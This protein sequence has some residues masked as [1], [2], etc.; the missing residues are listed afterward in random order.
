MATAA[1]NRMVNTTVNQRREPALRDG[2]SSTLPR[3]QLLANA[4][5]AASRRLVAVCW[6]AILMIAKG[7]RP[8]PRHADWHSG[9]LHDPANDDAIAEHVE[10]V[11]IP[12]AG[13]ARSR[14][15]A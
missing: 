12:F 13:R 4:T 8:H 1:T 10:V 7:Q 6:R 5:I 2:L 9:R 15:R 11:L 14:R 3:R